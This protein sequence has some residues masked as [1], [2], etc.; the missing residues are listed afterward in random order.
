MSFHRYRTGTSEVGALLP[1]SLFRY[2]MEVNLQSEQWQGCSHFANKPNRMLCPTETASQS[3]AH[4][5]IGNENTFFPDFNKLLLHQC[6]LYAHDIGMRP[7]VIC[8]P[9][10]QPCRNR[11]VCQ[12]LLLSGNSADNTNHTSL[13]DTSLFC[14]VFTRV[15]FIDTTCRPCLLAG[16]YSLCEQA[17]QCHFAVYY[18]C[19]TAVGNAERCDAGV[20]QWLV[21]AVTAFKIA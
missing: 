5:G 7:Q 2:V 20:D 1:L 18:T 11:R 8:L 21:V 19:V 3:L 9:W 13:G 17:I 14:V 15:L 16:V 12:R 10:H 4:Y 6:S